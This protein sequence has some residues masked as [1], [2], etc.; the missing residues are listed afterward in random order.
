MSKIL[1][2]FPSDRSTAFLQ[3]IIK[4]TQKFAELEIHQPIATIESHEACIEVIQHTNADLIIF[5]GHGHSDK[6]L[7]A[8][9]TDNSDRLYREYRQNGFINKQNL[10]IFAGKQVIAFSCDSNDKIGKVA[11]EKGAQVFVGFGY[12]PTDWDMEV[13]T[14]PK[15]PVEEV[16]IFNTALVDIFSHAVNYSITNSFTFQQFEKVFKVIVHKK[17]LNLIGKG[18][19]ID[20]WIIQNLYHLKTEIKKFGNIDS[21]LSARSAK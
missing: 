3:S 7:G 12:I 13:E 2:I 15:L 1:F 16:E 8:A 17:I 14:Y 20:D 6:L 9:C 21:P 11:I 18:V 10:A 5:M 19:E 4:S